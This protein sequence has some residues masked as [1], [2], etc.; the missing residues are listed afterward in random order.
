MLFQ[1]STI[2]I[3]LKY[4]LLVEHFAKVFFHSQ[5][6]HLGEGAAHKVATYCS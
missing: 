3:L 1:Q 4:D 2:L 6:V 5:Y